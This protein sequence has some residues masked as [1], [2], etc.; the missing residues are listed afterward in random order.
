MCRCTVEIGSGITIAGFADG[1]R[2]DKP[3]KLACLKADFDTQEIASATF[4][5]RYYTII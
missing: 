2:K 1:I 3:L 4:P 5:Y